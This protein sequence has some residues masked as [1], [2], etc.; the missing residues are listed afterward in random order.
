[1]QH[2]DAANEIDYQ[3]RPLRGAILG[4]KKWPWV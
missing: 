1:M 2:S 3:R 4:D